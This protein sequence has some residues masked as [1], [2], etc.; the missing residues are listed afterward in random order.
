VNGNQNPNDPNQINTAPDEGQNIPVNSGAPQA[1]PGAEITPPQ[2]TPP[3]AP[4]PPPMQIEPEAGETP[5]V[6]MF[7]TSA[8]A[9]ETPP[10]TPESP[11]ALTQPQPEPPLNPEPQMTPPPPPPPAE[12]LPTAPPQ[13]SVYGSPSPGQAAPETPISEE[14]AEPLVPADYRPSPYGA[15]PSNGRGLIGK[16]LIF[17]F[18][19]LIG[20]GAAFYF[21]F[22][23]K[24]SLSLTVDPS[25]S[26]VMIDNTNYT[27]K[28]S[29]PIQLSVGDHNLKVSKDGYADHQEKITLKAMEHKS[30]DV[31][32]E[33]I[34]VATK[35][36]DE[37]FKF[38][39]LSADGK[40]ILGLG[41]GD[42]TFY[43]ITA[44]TTTDQNTTSQGTNDQTTQTQTQNS[45]SSSTSSTESPTST[46]QTQPN[47]ATTDQSTS[48]TTNATKTAISP[49]TFVGIKDVIWH[50]SK[51]L[52]II[53]V[54]NS[55]SGIGSSVFGKA[56]ITPNITSTWLYDF[57]RYDLLNQTAIL[58]SEYIGDIAFSPDGEKVAYYYAA[59]TGEKSLVIADKNNQNQERVLDLRDKAIDN[60]KIA[61]SGDGAYISLVPQ[62]SDYTKNYL[63]LY[64]VSSK[65]LEQITQTGDK[66]GA[67]FSPDG[68]NI[69]VSKF[70]KSIDSTFLV[71]LLYMPVG[72][73]SEGTDL[74]IETGLDQFTW[75][76]D[77]SSIIYAS[78]DTSGE[79]DKI[80]KINA[81]NKEKTEYSYTADESLQPDNLVLSDDGSIL[82]FLSN[83]R[84]FSLK[85]MEKSK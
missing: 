70:A 4:P 21:L 7:E 46:S 76:T 34:S 1:A 74:E 32:L 3:Q 79:G 15:P 65:K 26:T 41:N 10:A 38:I 23:S 11:A 78:A 56:K 47:T 33:Q 53:K 45:S 25:D 42:K 71:T 73:P 13:E 28:T 58:W 83:G 55:A 52:A 39:T 66:K 43:R 5:P 30:L 57:K 62:S 59:P 64:N 27:G 69:V 63:Y 68:K 9:P 77:S 44:T 20:G 60:P 6:D 17:I 49:D 81:T 14:P 67:T 85:L 50:K 40:D 72:G 54:D 35:L 61:W 82:Y 36:L 24:A 8:P 31:K 51:E 16:I 12:Q 29:S 2:G 19:L 80:Q 22:Y 37:E 18:V 48:G 75:S 84:P